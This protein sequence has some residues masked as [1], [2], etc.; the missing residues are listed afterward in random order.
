MRDSSGARLIHYV[1]AVVALDGL[2][3]ATMAT[4]MPAGAAPAAEERPRPL[5][6]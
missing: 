4:V 3:V 5:P 6:V 1:A 2:S